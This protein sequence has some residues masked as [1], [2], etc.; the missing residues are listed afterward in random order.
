[1]VEEE[2]DVSAEWRLL[3]RFKLRSGQLDTLRALSTGRD[4]LCRQ[5]TGSGKS[6]VVFILHVLGCVCPPTP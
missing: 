5:P 4:V 3:S 6:M 1:M 2:G